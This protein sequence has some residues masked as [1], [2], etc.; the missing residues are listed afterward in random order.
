MGGCSRKQYAIGVLV[1]IQLF[2]GRIALCY[3]IG[4]SVGMSIGA[5]AIYFCQKYS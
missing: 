4:M 1:Q 3:S 5:A 2:C